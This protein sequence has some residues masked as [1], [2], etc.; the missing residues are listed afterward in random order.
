M[1]IDENHNHI[2][3]SQITK[4]RITINYDDYYDDYEKMLLSVANICNYIF[5]IFT[6]LNTFTLSESSYKNRVRLDFDNSFLLSNFRSST[7]SKLI[8]N[9]RSF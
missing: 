2:F 1:F 7:L 3:K 8:V 5:T 6:H 9:L 4:L